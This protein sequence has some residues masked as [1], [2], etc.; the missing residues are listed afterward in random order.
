MIILIDFE[1][2]K[3]SLGKKSASLSEE[4]IDKRRMQADRFAEA[5]F[6]KWLRKKNG[7]SLDNSQKNDKNVT[8]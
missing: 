3:K 4:E 6:D 8:S 7:S 5:I 2:F 1:A